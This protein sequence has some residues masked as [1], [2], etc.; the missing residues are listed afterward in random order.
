MGIIILVGIIILII[1]LLFYIGGKVRDNIAIDKANNETIINVNDAVAYLGKNKEYKH[2]DG[3]L[4]LTN[5]RLLFYKQR[6]GWLNIVPFLG[7]ALSSVFIDKNLE[8]EIPVHQITHYLFKPVIH[9][10]NNG[11]VMKEEGF[12]T[13]F[14]KQ[15]EVFDFDIQ[16]LGM[17][18]NK[19]PD[20]LL[21]L[22]EVQKTLDNPNQYNPNK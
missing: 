3:I 5:R 2:L 1:I 12:T 21:K 19:I 16:A 15:N 22:E 10:S 6:F 20:I 8:L 7:E 9:Y 14:T 4:F 18:E 11:F 17:S 13:I